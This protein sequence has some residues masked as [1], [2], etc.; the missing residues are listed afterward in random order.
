MSGYELLKFLHVAAV[1]A[2]LGGP[3]VLQVLQARLRR[4]GDRATLMG[5]GRQME[6]M[7]KVYFSPLAAATL[8][9]GI[10]MVAT[11]DGMS[12]GDPW[13]LIGLLGIAVTMGIGLGVIAPTGKKLA[14]A[15]QA[16]P[17]DGA[18][19]AALS[20][21]MTTLTIINI[22]ILFFV[23]WAMVVKLGL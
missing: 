5:I 9:T 12:F 20:Q 19:I 14:E 21:R 22:V 10:L 17:P 7:G 2:W 23:V 15:S 8:L 4:A 11:T 16:T 3:V 6:T 18:T 1:I 13:I